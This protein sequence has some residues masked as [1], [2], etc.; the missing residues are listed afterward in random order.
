MMWKSDIFEKVSILADLPTLALIFCLQAWNF[1]GTWN[2]VLLLLFLL[3]CL[4]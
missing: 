1:Q 2:T 3:V 4:P